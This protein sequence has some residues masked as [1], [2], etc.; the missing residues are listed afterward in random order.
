MVDQCV[1]VGVDLFRN[2]PVAYDPF[3]FYRHGII[4]SLHQVVI[5]QV[6]AGKSAFAKAFLARE[7]VLGR[8]LFILDPKGEYSALAEAL[9][10]PSIVLR[11]IPINIL[12]VAKDGP[13]LATFLE[14]L[15]VPLLDS[16]LAPQEFDVITT[17]SGW[18]RKNH[19]VVTMQGVYDALIHPEPWKELLSPG[20]RRQVEDASARV[21]TTIKRYLPGGDLGGVFSSEEPSLIG[22]DLHV[23]VSALFNSDF[24][25]VIFGALA[26]YLFSQITLDAEEKIFVIDESWMAWQHQSVAKRLGEIAKL[27]RSYQCSLLLLFHRLSDMPALA[28]MEAAAVNII[29]ECQTRVMFYQHQSEIEILRGFF[30]LSDTLLDLLVGLSKAQCV[31]QVGDFLTSYLSVVLSEPELAVCRTDPKLGRADAEP[32]R[33]IMQRTKRYAQL[34]Q[35]SAQPMDE[36]GDIKASTDQEQVI[37]KSKGQSETVGT[38][39]RRGRPRKT[40]SDDQ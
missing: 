5:G 13:S 1:L 22:T 24:N 8:R 20:T 21:A 16:P 27:S 26:N 36:N 29:K 6:G 4:T 12:D 31:F 35:K 34:I 23:N 9:E 10:I 25:F 18:V 19:R 3:T 39:R 28:E 2:A 38:K 11:A 7:K 33:Q 40:I 37:S 17:V 15:V 32:L 30:G 14:L